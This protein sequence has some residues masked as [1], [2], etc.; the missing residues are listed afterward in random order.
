MA[1]SF[2]AASTM[3]HVVFC[4]FLFSHLSMFSESLIRLGLLPLHATILTTSKIL[5]SFD[6]SRSHC[7][8]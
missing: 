7:L 3:L 2:A 8:S 5:F 4:R 6:T 1:R